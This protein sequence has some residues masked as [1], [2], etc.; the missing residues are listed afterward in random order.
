M[1][2]LLGPGCGGALTTLGQKEQVDGNGKMV[3]PAA[4]KAGGMGVR[5]SQTMWS[6]S[7]GA[8]GGNIKLNKTDHHSLFST[9]LISSLYHPH[10]KLEGIADH[11]HSLYGSTSQGTGQGRGGQKVDL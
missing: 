8:R 11:W 9:A 7:K 10:V 5:I 1:L 2:P 3:A 6:G 4:G